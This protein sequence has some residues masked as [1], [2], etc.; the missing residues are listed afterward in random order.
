MRAMAELPDQDGQRRR[1]RRTAVL[2]GI[3]AA[4]FYFGFILATG[5]KA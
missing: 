4:L 2:L 1:I 3:L 5:L